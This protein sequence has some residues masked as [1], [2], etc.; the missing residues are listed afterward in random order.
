MLPPD[1]RGSQRTE[2]ERVSEIDPLTV[3]LLS[4]SSTHSIH[5][6]SLFARCLRES[7]HCSRSNICPHLS[8]P[9][10]LSLSHSLSSC[11]APSYADL[12]NL[13]LGSRFERL[14]V[15]R[16]RTWDHATFQNDFRDISYIPPFFRLAF[17]EFGL[18]LAALNRFSHLRHR[19]LAL[20]RF[21]EGS[22]FPG[23]A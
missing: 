10:Q 16:A 1:E 15:T 3:F 8:L 2:R 18:F 22:C 13:V 6:V 21:A 9:P 17:E 4:S 12:S 19:R 7:P 14:R 20:S 23:A 5:R 11:F